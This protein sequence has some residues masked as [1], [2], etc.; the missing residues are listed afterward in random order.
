MS[1]W[2][3]KIET[4]ERKLRSFVQ[5]AIE[6]LDAAKDDLED[7]DPPEENFKELCAFATGMSR[8]L[9]ATGAGASAEL[10]S[11]VRNGLLRAFDIRTDTPGAE[12]QDGGVQ[13]L[14]SALEGL[15]SEGGALGIIPPN[16]EKVDNEED[17]TRGQRRIR[18]DNLASMSIQDAVT[19]MWDVL[20]KENRLEWGSDGFTLDMQ[21]KAKYSS[22]ADQCE[23]PLFNHVNENNAFWQRD[24]TKTFISL[25][26]NYE[27]ETGVAENFTSEEKQEMS[28]FLD[29][30][31]DT[32]V[33]RFAFEY[34]KVHGK[35][36]RC[37]KLRSITDFQ[38]ILF[39]IWFAPYRR[40]KAN[41]SSGFEHVFVGEEK[42][43]SIIGLHNWV[44]Y[45]LEEK[46]GNINYIGWAGK[47]D[48]D[49]SD[50]CHI[51]SI[52]FTWDDDDDELEAKS[53]STIVCGSTIEFEMAILSLCFLCSHQDGYT[54][55]V[56][57]TENC[58]VVCHSH[59][60]KYGGPKIGTAF[61]EIA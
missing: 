42:K 12:L 53:L 13:C 29:A 57:G 6:K 21:G 58:K 8:H 35:D 49:Y 14:R 45:Y 48:S 27:R 52:K 50:D 43:G 24:A 34:I 61:I 10:R 16:E 20:D 40:Y 56:L 2:S 11:A 44:Q 18:P 9:K 7:D 26:D 4:V 15:I 28:E 17:V 51:V 38:N 41:D 22:T 36:Y 37:K 60:V 3:K 47:Q 5:F 33:V 23:F 59:K 1:A 32:A 55:V 39:D 31:C 46:K 19:Y 30:L 54:P 25:L